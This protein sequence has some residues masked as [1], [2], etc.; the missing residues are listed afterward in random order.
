MSDVDN[1]YKLNTATSIGIHAIF[2][3]KEFIS[4]WKEKSLNLEIYGNLRTA[5]RE[6]K[7]IR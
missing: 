7:E 5:L 4:L 6:F 1:S 3:S 2:L